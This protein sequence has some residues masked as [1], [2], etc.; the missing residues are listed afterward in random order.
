MITLVGYIYDKMWESGTPFGVGSAGSLILFAI[1]LLITFVQ[2]RVSKNGFI[3][4]R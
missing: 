3:I 4:R 1:I 2:F